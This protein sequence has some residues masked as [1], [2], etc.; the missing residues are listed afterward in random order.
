MPK[1]SVRGYGITSAQGGAGFTPLPHAKGNLL[2][3]ALW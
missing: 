1:N 2:P 3:K